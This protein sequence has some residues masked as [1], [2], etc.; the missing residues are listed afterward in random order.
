RD[1][2]DRTGV[3]IDVEASGRVNIV[4]NDEA[5]AVKALRIIRELTATAEIGKKSGQAG[6][7]RPKRTM[8][9]AARRRIAA[10]QRARWA[11]VKGQRKVV[12]IAQTGKAG[13]RHI[14]AAG[15]AQIAAAARARWARIK[16]RKK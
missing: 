6:T 2:M 10:A 12:P 11:T 8:S 1:I 14:S 3:K 9:A 15:R 5:C 16:T 4:S 13:K 7:A